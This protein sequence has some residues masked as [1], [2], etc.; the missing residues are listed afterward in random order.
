MDKIKR[1]RLF[2]DIE[3]S[4][5]VVYAWRT[6]YNMTVPPENIIKE[7]AIICVSWKWEGE[8][9]VH[10]LTWNKS[11][12][13]KQL[14]KKFIKILDSADEIIGHNS[15]RFD[16]RWLRG[17]ALY[18]GIP[19]IPKYTQTDTMKM[20]KGGLNLNSYKLDYIARYLG[21]GAKT[22]HSGWDMWVNIMNKD[23]KALKEMVTY[24]ENDVI[25]LEKVY[26]KLKTYAKP[27]THHAHLRGA[28]KYSC[29]DCGSH[30]VHLNKTR[31]T[32]SGIIKREM[33]CQETS[34]GRNYTIS[35]RAYVAYVKDKYK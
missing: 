21:V 28:A 24:C 8:K 14:L 35:D 34:C 27:N 18:H 2:Y 9:S 13:D 33:Q 23:A 26:N 31:T 16:I 1:R 3:T 4:P 22:K 12:D 10:T 15:D 29:P 6:G 25:I 32:A 17:R 11:Q 20:A 19:M 5:N 30:K 7:R